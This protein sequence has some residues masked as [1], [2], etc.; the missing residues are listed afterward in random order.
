MFQG[1]T[2]ASAGT[3]STSISLA[4]DIMHARS[5]RVEGIYGGPWALLDGFLRAVWYYHRLVVV[6][7]IGSGNLVSMCAYWHVTHSQ[8]V[9]L[10]RHIRL[11]LP[12]LQC[13]CV[14]TPIACASSPRRLVEPL[15]GNALAKNRPNCLAAHVDGPPTN[16][17]ELVEEGSIPT[18][19]QSGE[20]LAESR[21][22]C[23]LLVCSLYCLQV[24]IT[25]LV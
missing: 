18:S 22:V 20:E 24:I 11:P 21:L 9:S 15:R 5:A 25:K 23:F 16:G 7:S 4:R 8:E 3:D 12:S 10:H 17:V 6:I 13:A 2:C 14:H 19:Q 1:F